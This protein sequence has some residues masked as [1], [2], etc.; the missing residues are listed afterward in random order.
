MFNSI[1]DELIN[2]L[3]QLENDI[4]SGEINKIIQQYENGLGDYLFVVR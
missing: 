2:G 1:P 4:R 3:K